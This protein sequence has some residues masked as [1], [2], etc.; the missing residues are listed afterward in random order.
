M[1][2]LLL[3]LLRRAQHQRPC[4][5]YFRMCGRGHTAEYGGRGRQ[6]SKVMLD[7]FS[8]FFFSFNIT[9]LLRF[10]LDIWG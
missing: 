8:C 2:L 10:E 5:G 9:F 4:N 6:G 3:L 7:R 1:S